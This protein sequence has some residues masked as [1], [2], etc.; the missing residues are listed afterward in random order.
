M[1][2]RNLVVRVTTDAGISGYGQIESV[3]L[4]GVWV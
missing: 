1:I 3:G 4:K 2:G